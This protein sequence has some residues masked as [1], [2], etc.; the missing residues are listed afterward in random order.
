M[1][2]RRTVFWILLGATLLVY[3][4]I[5]LW[6]LPQISSAA[7]GLTPFGLRP[8]GYNL[9]EAKAFLTAL[10]TEGRA[11]YLGPQHGLDTAYPALLAAT[12][13][14]AT[15]W[16]FGDLPGAARVLLVLPA[17]AGTGFDYHENVRVAGLLRE[18][19]PTAAMVGA[20]SFATVAKSV[21][22]TVAM[23][24][25]LVGLGLRLRSYRRAGR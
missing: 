4:A 25:V 13:I 2:L 24:I 20:A 9:V 17:L 16:G 23:I 8:A 21:A 18:E 22:T 7:G 11:F 6:S 19:A 15:L 10:G 3:G 1:P 14:W 5:V 12:L